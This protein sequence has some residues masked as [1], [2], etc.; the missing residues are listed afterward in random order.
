MLKTL[1]IKPAKLDFLD[2]KV[3]KVDVISTKYLVFV[4]N[5]GF[6]SI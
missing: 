6:N 2:D 4:G 1:Q 5:T 3:F